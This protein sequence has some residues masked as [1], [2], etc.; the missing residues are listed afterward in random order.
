M[1][2]GTIKYGIAAFIKNFSYIGAL[3]ISLNVQS[4][5]ILGL[6]MIV[7][8]I[9]GIIRSGT[10]H[11]WRSV[12]SHAATVGITAKCLVIAIPFFLALAGHGV[13]IELTIIASS[14]LKI[15]IVSEL[16]SILSNIQSI[17]LRREVQEFDAVNYLLNKLRD[18]L[19]HNIKTKSNNLK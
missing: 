3:F 6:F 16:Y 13:G 4:Y 11:G 15:L 5:S 12:T 7:D 10:I 8:T 14:A 19:E 9:T 2:I 1:E 17:R 18:F